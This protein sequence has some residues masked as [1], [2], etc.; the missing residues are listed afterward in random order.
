MPTA[1]DALTLSLTHQLEQ[2]LLRDD[3]LYQL[4]LDSEE[5]LEDLAP[6]LRE[7]IKNNA[8][9]GLIQKLNEIVR[10]KETELNAQLLEST[11][12]INSCIDT[13]DAIHDRLVKLGQNLGNVSQNLNKSVHD[14]VARKNNLIKCKQIT[15]KINETLLV[16]TLCI[17]VL[18]N[19]NKI[20]EMIKQN[21]YFSAMKL[22]D[23][24]TNI[25][26]PQVEKFSFALK[27]YDSIPHLTKMIKDESFD[28]IV[29]WLLLNLERKIPVIGEAIYENLEELQRNWDQVK[30]LNPAFLPYKLNSPIEVL[31]RDPS[32][33]FDIFTDE[34]L[35]I[36][37]ATLYDGILVYQTL[38]ESEL[39][40]ALYQK[41]WMKKY[42]RVIH[43]I[44]SATA[45]LLAEFPD[46]MALDEY[47]V[48]IAAF[49]V[50]DKQINIATRFALR[51]AANSNDLWNS[52]VTKLKPVLLHHLNNHVFD[53]IDD[54][55]RFKDAVGDFLHVMELHGFKVTELYEVLMIVFHEHFAPAV[56]QEFRADFISSIQSDRYMPI[57]VDEED[58]YDKIMKICW[59]QDDASFAPQN[60][61]AFP[62]V[63]PFSED[64]LRYC[65][66]IRGLLEDVLSFL[67][68]HYSY[69][70]NEI[71]NIVLNDIF[72]R[73]LGDVKGVGIAWDIK[74]FISKNASNKEVVAQSYTNLEYYLY[75]LYELGRLIDRKLRANIGIGLHN[76]DASDTFTLRAVEE[77][78]LVRKFSESTIFTM[79]DDKIRALLDTVEY[80]NWLPQEKNEEANFFIKDFAMFLD[81][82][83]SSIFSN[84]PVSIR[85][86]G[87]FRTYD[88]VAEH[89]LE[90]LKGAEVYNRIAIENFNLDVQYI[91]KHMTALY[92]AHQEVAE[93]ST[94]NVALESTFTELRQCIDLLLLED[95]SEFS[96][97]PSFRMR[98]FDRVRF[99]DGQSLIAKMQRDDEP[100]EYVT[101]LS[102]SSINA[103]D[104]SRAKIKKFGNRLK[105]KLDNE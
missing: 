7:L 58:D 23:E 28:N 89:F 76:I 96:S 78:S 12:E 22:I 34:Q 51:S 75:S 15:A 70:L 74:D 97:N 92:A 18:E 8:L 105:M 21:K 59:Y 19:T 49:F 29:N 2:L 60:V 93:D 86:L 65:A 83:F 37:L 63:L 103:L 38:N 16:L 94:T 84:L 48:K 33:N 17:Q 57:L 87:L 81:N 47:L 72:E 79:V 4:N 32:L 88:F 52:Y 90:V 45:E 36:S 14:L 104:H 85:T 9:G 102:A 54:L 95:Y 5:Y 43:P 82:L 101:E 91:E 64:Y 20:H 41:E 42:N 99:E 27:I 39:L 44:T 62:V 6:I 50:M 98:H 67:N 69:E 46:L 30:E 77:F 73:V 31:I 35:Q 26:L 68:Q 100:E 13:I 10:S 56:I 55:S 25:H 3:D 24:L 80:D 11:D 61:K 71:K 53:T 1:D 66:G 40:L